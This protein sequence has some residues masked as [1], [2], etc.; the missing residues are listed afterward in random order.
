M[1]LPGS[2]NFFRLKD[3]Y[4]YFISSRLKYKLRMF[5]LLWWVSVH[6]GPKPWHWWCVKP[7][8]SHD[9][10][11][12]VKQIWKKRGKKG[13]SLQ[14][15]GWRKYLW[16]P[17]QF[18]NI[19]PVIIW[20]LHEPVTIVASVSTKLVI[21][22]GLDKSRGDSMWGRENTATIIPGKPVKKS[23]IETKLLSWHILLHLFTR[24]YKKIWGASAQG[25]WEDQ[26]RDT[27][28]VWTST[29]QDPPGSSWL[30]KDDLNFLWDCAVLC[31]TDLIIWGFYFELPFSP[32]LDMATDSK[33]SLF[34][35]VNPPE[36]LQEKNPLIF[37]IFL[38]CVEQR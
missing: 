1:K 16:Y 33:D 31:W 32:Y 25:C 3:E 34:I 4:F 18:A 28:A 12:S 22:H 9:C 26:N 2:T 14:P 5:S 11:D 35:L 19:C 27:K 7:N 38:L 21:S 8:S 30:K 24:K 13:S 6:H 23:P 29:R 17:D 36:T 20:C 37:T 15:H 10:H